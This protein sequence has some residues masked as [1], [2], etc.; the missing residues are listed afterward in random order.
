[1][2]KNNANDTP[3]AGPP[4]EPTAASDPS[5]SVPDAGGEPVKQATAPMATTP[6]TVEGGVSVGGTAGSPSGATA[7]PADPVAPPAPASYEMPDDYESDALTQ[8]RLWVEENPVLAVVAA[9]G[10][11]L[12]V[13]RLVMALIPEP[14]PPSFSS[15]VEKR[16]KQLRKDAT[17]YAD[18]AGAVVAEQLKR[19]ANALS[20]AAE[21]V[22]EKAEVGYERSKDVAEVVGDAVKAAVAGV[23]VK[24][25]DNW[26]SKIRD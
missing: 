17:V 2:A 6:G 4:A 22:A 24:K 19:A 15:R 12:V 16:A 20:E 8:T 14:E 18:D 1:M 25:A 9:A 21:V 13:G 23:V 11:G 3:K 26:I 5:A 10:I 7:R